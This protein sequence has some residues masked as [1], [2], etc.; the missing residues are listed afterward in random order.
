MRPSECARRAEIL[1]LSNAELARL[2]S[3]DENTVAKFLSGRTDARLSTLSA[4]D[5]ALSA[6]ELETLRRLASRHP[7][8]AIE[9]AT[10]ALCPDTRRSAAA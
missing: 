6:A 1:R 5:D 9:A 4:I 8:A 3:L 7:S 2:S 10:V